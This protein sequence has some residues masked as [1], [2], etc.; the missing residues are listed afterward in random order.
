MDG[1]E[2]GHPAA[3]R[4]VVHDVA[5]LHIVL[6]D[7]DPDLDLFLGLA[8]ERGHDRLPGFEVAGRQ[9]A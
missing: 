2:E 4:R 5:E 8:D 9:S 6:L 7:D 1:E 3:S